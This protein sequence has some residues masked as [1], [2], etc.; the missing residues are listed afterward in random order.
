MVKEG[1]LAYVTGAER[2]NVLE[3]ARAVMDQASLSEKPGAL[4]S[5]HALMR[6]SR[7]SHQAGY[8]PPYICNRLAY[9]TRALCPMSLEA[10][11]NQL[12]GLKMTKH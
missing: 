8:G 2:F 1:L 4:P 6:I 10:C 9:S 12:G 5:A 3:S 7:G 11:A